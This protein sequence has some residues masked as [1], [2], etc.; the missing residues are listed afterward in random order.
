MELQL[1]VIHKDKMVENGASQRR[2]PGSTIT[3]AGQTSTIVPDNRGV[4]YF[5]FATDSTHIVK[6]TAATRQNTTFTETRTIEVSS[7]QGSSYFIGSLRNFITELYPTSAAREYTTFTIT[8]TN[9]VEVLGSRSSSLDERLGIITP[10]CSPN[11]KYL[12]GCYDTNNV[13][14]YWVDYKVT[15]DHAPTLTGGATYVANTLVVL[16]IF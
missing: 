11:I 14:H 3:T 13:R 9:T 2:S 1:Q 10:V 7:N 8:G 15:T 6:T 12:L 16:S 4:S 5:T